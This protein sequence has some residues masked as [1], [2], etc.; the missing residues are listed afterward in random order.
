MSSDLIKK[1]VDKLNVQLPKD[2]L[3]RISA[4]LEEIRELGK[5]CPIEQ[6]LIE[7]WAQA[8]AISLGIDTQD[9]VELSMLADII[10]AE[11]YDRRTSGDI[12]LNE[13]FDMQAVGV[14]SH[15][16]PILRK[17]PAVALAVK[18]MMKKR[19]D[20]IRRSFLATRESRAKYKQ[21]ESEDITTQF[22]KIRAEVEGKRKEL[23]EPEENLD[24]ETEDTRGD[25]QE[26]GYESVP[27]LEGPHP[28]VSEQDTQ[29]RMEQNT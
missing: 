6:M 1:Y 25:S 14:D 16:D 12:S 4:S 22:S 10:E 28:G 13:L 19:K 20:D 18:M 7:E 29:G 21:L 3:E 17:E 11:V 5:M 9:F 15:G 27:E 23:P 24:F 26:A 2:K 8:Y